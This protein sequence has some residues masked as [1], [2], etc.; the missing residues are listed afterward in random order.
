MVSTSSIASST[1]SAPDAAS[2]VYQPMLL[3]V[4][5]TTSTS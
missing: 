1:G 3:P 4:T 5:A 2:A